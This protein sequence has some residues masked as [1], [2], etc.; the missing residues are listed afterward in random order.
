MTL[1]SIRALIIA[2]LSI[3]GAATAVALVPREMTQQAAVP[4]P[5]TPEE[6]QRFAEAWAQQ[7]RVDPGV[8]AGTAK[9]VVVKFN[10]WLCSACKGMAIE[11]QPVFDKYQQQAPGAVK[12]VVKDWPWDSNCNANLIHGHE[13]SCQ[14]AAAVRMARD[15]GKGPAMEEWLFAE[16]ERLVNLNLAGP[17]AAAVIRAKAKELLGVADFDREYA[18]KAI[19][20]RRDVAEGTVLRIQ[21]TPVYF[22]N[23]VR[24]TVAEGPQIGANLPAGYLDLAI[25]IELGRGRGSR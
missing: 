5:L 25:T 15:R 6:R 18:A 4:P 8:P 16:Q 9:V 12:Y 2:V 14:A 19:E 11:Y 23:G 1:R 3:G 20:I 13:G 24:T 17:G 10:D 21:T 7:P 22:V